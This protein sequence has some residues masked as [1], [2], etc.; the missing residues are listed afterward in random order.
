MDLTKN[1]HNRPPVDQF[2]QLIQ[3]RAPVTCRGKT[4]AFLADPALRH[5]PISGLN[6]KA[7]E[8]RNATIFNHNPR[9]GLMSLFIGLLAFAEQPLLQAEVKFGILGG[10]ILAGLLGFLL[11]CLVKGKVPLRRAG[12]EELGPLRP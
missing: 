10:S 6:R 12:R 9:T 8:S 11:L 4:E 2:V 1:H 7:G 5:L 3:R